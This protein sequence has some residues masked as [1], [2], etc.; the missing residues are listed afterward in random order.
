MAWIGVSDLRDEWI[1]DSGATVLMMSRRKWFTSYTCFD[2]EISV[3]LG[4]NSTI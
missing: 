1:I 2:H 3:G 4:D